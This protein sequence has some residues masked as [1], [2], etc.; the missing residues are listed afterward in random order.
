LR[1]NPHSH[2]LF[3]HGL[4]DLIYCPVAHGEGRVVAKDANALQMLWES[5][6]I[7]LQYVDENGQLAG[8]P[9]NPNGSDANIA[10][11]CNAQGNVMGL[12]PHPEDHIFGWQNP[13]WHRGADGMLGL[14]LF[15]N[16]VRF[17]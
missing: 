6:Q 5:G 11:V 12:M 8:Y 4:D 14:P 10:S 17:A 1:P 9:Y 13:R 2:S 3:T 7:P 15:K 16:M